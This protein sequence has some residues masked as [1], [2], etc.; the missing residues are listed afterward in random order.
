MKR[1]LVVTLALFVAVNLSYGQKD[2]VLM[3]VGENE[4]TKSEFEQIFFK[5]YKK[6]TVSKEDLDEYM[7]LYKKFKLKVTEAESLGLDTAQKFVKEL[8]GYQEQLARPYLVD[9]V[10][11]GELIKEA[12]QRSL[13]EV[14]AS[15]IMVKIS[16]DARPQDTLA[17]YNRALE[18][19]KKLND[20][21]DFVTLAKGRNGS[22][23]PSAQQNGGDLGYFTVF[24]MVYP[25]ESAAF[26]M[27][28]GEISNPVRSR[29]GYHII[30]KTDEREARGEIK[31][32]H[33]MIKTEKGKE[34]QNQVAKEKGEEIY[35]LLESGANFEE[36]AKKY[37]DDK[38]SGANGG[39]LPWFG[40]GRMVKEFED[41]A[42]SITKDGEFI[43]PIKTAYGWHI[44]KRI[45]VKKPDDFEKSKNYLKN[46]IQKDSRANVT[47]KSFISKLKKDY[48]FKD[49][50][51]DLFK[52]L[53]T[54]IDSS[55][56]SGEWTK[57]NVTKTSQILFKLDGKKYSLGEFISHLEAKQRRQEPSELKK[58]VDTKYKNYID[59][60]IIEVEKSHLKEKYPIKYGALLKEYRD[61]ILLF[62]LMDEKVWSKAVKDTSG[63]KNYYEN[64]KDQFVWDERADAEIYACSNEKNAKQVKALLDED[65]TPDKVMS[66]VNEGTQLNVQ[67]DKGLFEYKQKEIL[68]G[69]NKGVSRIIEKEGTYYVV[70]IND[71]KEKSTK[72]LDEAKGV[73][74]S[75]Y[76]EYLEST[77]LKELEGKYQIKVN[78]KVLYSIKK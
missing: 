74:T 26:K 33:I 4:V 37:S 62:E 48:K 21:A 66:M 61:G 72:E 23:D 17:A 34:K 32:A 28:V 3:T 55:I 27:K 31:C 63:L 76:Q 10:R 52:T 51:N 67:L 65:E 78:E 69:L 59:Q 56:F 68:A 20:G 38:K 25:F 50:S 6:E 46:K 60:K 24:A 43:E 44:I 58:Y 41:A 11:F 64:N 18:I 40:T 73:I 29:Y 71:V 8:Q 36:L 7:I 9:T 35:K 39:V 57:N 53:Y 12:H 77:W 13:K 49:Y 42:F 70:R 30:K 1:S 19:K 75:K 2:P 15:H 22:D 45:E 5:N 54:E 14:R 47:K 16:S